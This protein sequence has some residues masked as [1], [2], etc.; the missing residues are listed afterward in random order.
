MDRLR[1]EQDRLNVG[2]SPTLEDLKQMTYLEQL[3]KEVMRLIPPVAVALER[4]SLILN[5]G[6]T[7]FLKVGRS[8]IKLPK[9]IKMKI[10]IPKAIALTQSV[11][12]QSNLRRN[13]LV[14]VIFLLVGGVTRM[15]W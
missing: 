13:K 6:V 11:L 1:A 7:R 10:F 2:D 8:S 5:L 15:H 3:F 14:L 12:T 4:R 9:P